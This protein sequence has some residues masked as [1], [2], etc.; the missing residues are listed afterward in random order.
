MKLRQIFHIQTLAFNRDTSIWG[1]DGQEFDPSRWLDPGR[2]PPS[3][4][5]AGGFSG[6]FSFIEG[7]RMCIGYRLG[8]WLN[9]GPPGALLDRDWHAQR[10]SSSKSSY[11]LFFDGLSL[12][13][14]SLLKGGYRQLCSLTSPG[15]WQRGPKCR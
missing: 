6:I 12:Q 14:M 9:F 4:N 15:G 8:E 13:V 5:T 2:L 3:N 10:C 1:E 11:R 7:P